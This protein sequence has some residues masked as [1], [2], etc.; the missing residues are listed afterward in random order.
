MQKTFTGHPRIHKL[1]TV[2]LLMLPMH[3]CAQDNAALSRQWQALRMQNGHF[4]GAA[5]NA[6]IDAWQGTKHRLMQQLAQRAG[7]ERWTA[8][9]L[10]GWMGEADRVLHAGEEDHV[11]VLA[12]AQWQG[13]AGG[14]LW[15]YHWRGAHDQL[16]FALRDGRVVAVGWVAALE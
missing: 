11:R 12:Q 9:Q 8:G 7:H 4:D 2:L 13:S 6:E 1:V 5:W 16:A 3:G 14:E 10:K 15:L